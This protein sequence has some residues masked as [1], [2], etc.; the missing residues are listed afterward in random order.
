M[1]VPENKKYVLRRPMYRLMK[2]HSGHWPLWYLSKVPGFIRKMDYMRTASIPFPD[3]KWYK[4]I[5]ES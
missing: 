3:K 4:T 5:H 1:D 2:N